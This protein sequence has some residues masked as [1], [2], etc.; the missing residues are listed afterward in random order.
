MRALSLVYARY[1]E[2]GGKLILEDRVLDHL[3]SVDI[4]TIN[5]NWIPEW[6]RKLYPTLSR[7]ERA[8]RFDRPEILGGLPPPKPGEPAWWADRKAKRVAAYESKLAR[9]REER[10][11]EEWQREERLRHPPA[12]A[13]VP[14]SGQDACPGPCGH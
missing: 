7:A 13:D 11:R 6:G 1:R 5:R 10:L 8:E 14:P 12:P 9:Q 3:G 4:A 2:K